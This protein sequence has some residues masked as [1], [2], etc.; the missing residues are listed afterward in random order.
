MR[1]SNKIVF[2]DL[3]HTLLSTNTSYQFSRF[4]KKRG[5]FS[6]YQML[7]VLFYKLR[8]PFSSM[9]IA[10]L[11]N[12]VFNRLLKGLSLKMLEQEADLFLE[13]FPFFKF[14]L[15]PYDLLQKARLEGH[16]T[17]IL[18]SSPDFLAKRFGALFGASESYGTVYAVDK[19]G[20]LCNIAKLMDGKSK[21][22]FV[23][24]TLGR[25]GRRREDAIAYTD[26]YHDL[27]LLEAVGCPVVVNPDFRL[28]SA[29]KKN[30]W[31]MI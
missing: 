19:D 20:L 3:D 21:A 27:P 2:F 26:S 9:T 22:A 7:H 23:A 24:D 8:F 17:V 4:L 15:A 29:A 31:S 5:V 18:T 13:S 30:G 28:L 25:L 10:D 6:A 11:H 14:Y 16:Y 1:K 12:Q